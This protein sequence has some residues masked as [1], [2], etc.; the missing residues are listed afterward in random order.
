MQLFSLLL[1]LLLSELGLAQISS[2]LSRDDFPSYF[3]FG[4]GTSAYQVEGAADEDGR[5]PSIWDTFAHA[6]MYTDKSTGDIASDEYHKYKEDVQLMVETGL[7]AYRFSISWSRLL[8]NGRGPVNPK[9]L[10]YYNN[11]INELINHGTFQT[12]TYF[13]FPYCNCT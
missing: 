12:H 1:L 7:E 2:Q 8:P 10:Q 5:T 3:I 11:L 13:R 6:G 9:G 4:S